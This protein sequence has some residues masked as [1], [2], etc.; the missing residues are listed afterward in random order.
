[1]DL[2]I[3][4]SNSLF[5]CWSS[6]LVVFSCRRPNIGNHNSDAIIGPNFA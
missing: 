6:M 2:T 3:N 1:M 5:V 4:S